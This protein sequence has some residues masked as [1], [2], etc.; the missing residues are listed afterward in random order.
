MSRELPAEVGYENSAIA[1]KSGRNAGSSNYPA[2]DWPVLALPARPHAL[3]QINESDGRARPFLRMLLPKDAAMPL[4]SILV[5]VAVVAMFA[6]F[7]GVLW[8]G[9]TQA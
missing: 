5:S 2:L 1:G 4:D 6:V 8:W 3:I 9:D 7:A